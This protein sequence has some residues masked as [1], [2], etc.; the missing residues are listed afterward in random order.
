MIKRGNRVACLLASFLLVFF[1]LSSAFAHSIDYTAY[2]IQ[3]QSSFNG[4]SGNFRLIEPVA[5]G[6]LITFN[7]TLELIESAGGG[8]SLLPVT[9]LFGVKNTGGPETPFVYFGTPASTSQPETITHVYDKVAGKIASL[10]TTVTAIAPDTPGSYHF[11]IQALDGFK[12][13]GFQPGEGIVIHFTVADEAI[14]EPVETVLTVTLAEP[15][16]IYKAPSNTLVATL[17]EK[18]SG[19]PVSGQ[20][21]DFFLNGSP[22]ATVNTD[23]NGDATY[24]FITSG[25]DVG[26]HTVAANYQGKDDFLA[27]SGSANQCVTYQ[28]IGYQ[29][30]VL[31]QQSTTSGLGIGLFQGKVIPVKIKIADFYNAPVS[32]AEA[33]VYFANTVAGSAEIMAVAIQPTIADDG[34]LMRYDSTADQYILN[35][36]ISGVSN[37][38]YNI[39]VGM[40]EGECA[41]GHWV[42]VRIGKASK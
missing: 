8:T 28:F 31:V 38:D 2:D 35:W 29:P 23:A 5:P 39:R 30:P 1:S 37:G 42:P 25:L 7:L 26:D 3:P 4:Q 20:M 40:E 9:V 27:S 17:T 19:A 32:T 41:T 15:G 34:S 6:T 33:R 11:K 22:V 24:D 16:I 14:V 10:M 12:S 18:V 21:V 13:K 36:N